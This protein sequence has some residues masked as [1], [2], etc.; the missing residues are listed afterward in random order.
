VD[1]GRETAFSENQ[2]VI[3]PARV[4]HRMEGTRGKGCPMGLL[5]E[6]QTGSLCVR[7]KDEHYP[8]TRCYIARGIGG[9][10]KGVFGRFGKTPRYAAGCF[11]SMVVD[12]LR[13]R[14]LLGP[15]LGQ[16]RW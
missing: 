12:Q 3:H 14:T 16:G 6:V 8:L 4:R 1:A 13:D 11:Q 2:S 10:P 9:W 7:R 5:I 15:R